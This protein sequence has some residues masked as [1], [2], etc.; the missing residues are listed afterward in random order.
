MVPCADVAGRD[1]VL[2]VRAEDDQVLLHWP[3]GELASIDAGR[4]SQLDRVL[5]VAG[6]QATRGAGH[7]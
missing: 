4:V 6:E 2:R 7:G 3:P 5:Y 1:Q